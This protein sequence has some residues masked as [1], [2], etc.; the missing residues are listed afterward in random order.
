MR[1]TGTDIPRC[2]AAY[3][4]GGAREAARFVAGAFRPDSPRGLRT[5]HLRTMTGTPDHVIAQSYA[6]MYTDPGAVGARPHSEAYLARRTCPALTV[7]TTRG[8]AAWERTTLGT[9]PGATGSRV[10]H[11]P[12]TGHY[13]H[14]EH[15]ER[16]VRLIRGW[17]ERHDGPTYRQH[18]GRG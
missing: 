2:L 6:G 8:A 3:R 5:A 10:E 11:W 9:G 4:A 18:D 1:R 7:R 12:D 15:P 14:E 13:L 17:T 16:T